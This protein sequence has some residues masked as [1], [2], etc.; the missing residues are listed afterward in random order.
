MELDFTLCQR[1]LSKDVEFWNQADCALSVLQNDP[2]FIGGFHRLLRAL[3]AR[4]LAQAQ[5][6]CNGCFNAA[7][8]S[9]DDERIAYLAPCLLLALCLPEGLAC[10]RS[11][12]A[13]EQIISDTL[14][15][16]ERWERKL[17]QETGFRGIR[18]VC[19][20]LYP[21]VGRLLQIGRL[22][23]EPYLYPLPYAIYSHRG[24]G[25]LLCLC[26]QSL[27]CSKEGYPLED[28]ADDPEGFSTVF[29]RQD[30]I[31]TA[32][33]ANGREGVFSKGPICIRAEDWDL[34]LTQG[35]PVVN[36]HIP[37]CGPL[38]PQAV[39]ISLA[40]AREFFAMQK[41]PFHIGVCDSWLLDPALAHIAAPGSNIY[42]FMQRF[43]KYP[44]GNDSSA[45]DYLF[46]HGMN[47][48]A[49][50]VA[51]GKNS[52]QKSVGAYLLSGGRLHDTGGF[53]LFEDSQHSP[54]QAVSMSN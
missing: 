23:Y 34:L 16:F 44:V 53:L 8:I 43:F 4:N 17:S 14:A 45:I 6:I 51:Q 15:D 41:F 30:G 20:L 35:Q 38:T 27:N 5:T 46:E 54:T 36:L 18:D 21:Y 22:Q 10:M 47:D 26:V 3:K 52:L 48:P 31:I 7:H 50:L 9:Y 32:N 11:I 25:Q 2:I 33:P 13:D 37:R 24:N 19:W 12:G 40:S 1:Y 39:D 29:S 28:A 42:Q 49:S